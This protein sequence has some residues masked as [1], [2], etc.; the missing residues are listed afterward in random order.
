[1]ALHRGFDSVEQHDNHIIDAWNSIV[2]KGDTVWILGD[3]TMEKRTNY[4]LLSRLKGYKKVVMGNHDMPQHARSLLEYVNSVCG[5]FKYSSDIILTHC[6]IHESEIKR[7]KLN[8]HGHVHANTLP[9]KR[10][11]NVCC[12]VVDYTPKLINSIIE[13]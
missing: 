12:E 3:I 7:F 4:H 5:M 8:I 1:M 9:D 10:Y 11:V 6:P 13:K 2:D